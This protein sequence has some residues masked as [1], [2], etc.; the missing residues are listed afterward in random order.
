MAAGLLAVTLGVLW[1]VVALF[2][3][4]TLAT[5]RTR[6]RL[7]RAIRAL[8]LE[9]QRTRPLWYERAMRRERAEPPA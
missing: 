2:V 8:D 4:A 6:R 1:G 3:A 9:R 5:R 7:E